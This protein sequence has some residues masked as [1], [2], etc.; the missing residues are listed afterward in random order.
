MES[1]PATYCELLTLL[2][3]HFC[4]P[5]QL[6]NRVN[7]SQKNLDR[8]FTSRL[9]GQLLERVGQEPCVVRGFPIC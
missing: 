5:S 9:V 1:R 6:P 7:F 3:I 2:A 8:I 4:F